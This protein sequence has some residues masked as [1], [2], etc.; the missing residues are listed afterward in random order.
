MSAH[1]LWG[2]SSVN[3]SRLRRNAAVTATVGAGLFVAMAAQPALAA[4]A[5]A[6]SSAFTA[7]A[8]ATLARLDVA[9]PASPLFAGGSGYVSL[10]NASNSVDSQAD[11]ASKA[12]ATFLAAE[13]LGQKPPAL[14]ANG[15]S[16][17]APPDNAA[18]KTSALF[19]FPANP[20]IQGQILPAS[21]H[22]RWNDAIACPSGP[23]DIAKSEATVASLEALTTKQ[24]ASLPVSIPGAAALPVGAGVTLVDVDKLLSSST[25]SSLVKVEGQKGL[26]VSSTAAIDLADMTLF[27]GTQ[28][29]TRIQVVSQPKLTATAA[30]TE[31][32]S[33]V[34]FEAPVLQITDPQGNVHRLDAPSKSVTIGMESLSQLPGGVQGALQQV[35]KAAPVGALPKLSAL[36]GLNAEKAYLAKISIGQVDG[37]VKEA[38]KA[39]GKLTMLKIELL[40]PNGNDPLSTVTLGEV[41]AETTAP[42]GGVVCGGEP[43]VLPTS[44]TQP[45]A[46]QL[47][48]TGSD[49]TL[50]IAGG[51]LLLL[52]G[53]FAMVATARRQ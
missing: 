4:P 38:N 48:V 30:G 34:D 44:T 46:G 16:Q 35:G 28:A 45:P 21:A 18:P 24:A 39:A 17:S 36:P 43:S 52:L 12:D 42:A 8:A 1:H 40:S 31:G 32:K 47:P 37:V 7:N 14:P 26:G 51:G 33:S 15:V 41:K 49:V 10:V 2:G 50:L 13:L 23:V 11:T 27:D 6:S 5:P 3:R 53:R 29:K 22:A 19:T 9:V 20:L 25:K